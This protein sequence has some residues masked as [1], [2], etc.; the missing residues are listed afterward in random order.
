[1]HVHILPRKGGDFKRNDDIYE[2]LETHDK[3]VKE[4]EWRSDEDM[5]KEAAQL[6]PY[7]K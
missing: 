7:F 4:S 3:N 6:R 1:M 5:A 2:A